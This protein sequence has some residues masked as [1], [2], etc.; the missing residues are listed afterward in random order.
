[1]RRAALSVC[2]YAHRWSVLRS[3]LPAASAPVA[4]TSE[5]AP[6]AAA[7]AVAA[8]AA[9]A[10]AVAAAGAEAAAKATESTVSLSHD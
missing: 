4:G 7:A 6:A 5:P 8:P 3:Q 9:G 1:V 2:C 10:A